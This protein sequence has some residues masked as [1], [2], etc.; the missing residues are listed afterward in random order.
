MT[1]PPEDCSYLV[2]YPS[3]S[4]TKSATFADEFDL[5]SWFMAMEDSGQID[6][7]SRGLSVFC[8][9]DDGRKAIDIMHP[10]LVRGRMER[11]SHT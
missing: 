9:T 3:G 5:G 4:T 6:R 2:Y 8:V 7:T 1:Y 11:R 10:R